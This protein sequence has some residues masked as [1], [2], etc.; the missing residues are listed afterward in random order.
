MADS[1]HKSNIFLHCVHKVENWLLVLFTTAIIVFSA[2]QIVLRN[3]FDSGIT[4]ISPLLGVLVFWIGMIGALVATRDNSHIKINVLSVYLT[5]KQKVVA[6]VIVNLFS[7]GVCLVLAYYAVEFLK[8][9]LTSTTKAFANVPVWVAE[10]IM[11][12]TFAL[13]GFRFLAYAIM[14]VV[15]LTKGDT[16]S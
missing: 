16:V 11:P 5:D 7:G 2:L 6:Q 12:V 3:L 14:H 15:A 10:V 4:W 13:M 1:N 9:D 8:L